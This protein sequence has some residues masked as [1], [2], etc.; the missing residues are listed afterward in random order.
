[1]R[2]SRSTEALLKLAAFLAGL[3]FAVPANAE[4]RPSTPDAIASAVADCWAAIGPKFVDQAVL[5]QRGWR[6]GT[7]S[8]AGG[9]AAQAPKIFGKNGSD[10]LVMLM[11]TADKPMCS[12]AARVE[13]I[14]AVSKAAQAVQKTL[15]AGDPQV[16]T[17]RSGKSVVFLSLPRL[18]TFDSTGTKDKPAVRIVAGYNAE[19]K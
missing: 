16:I 6:A 7:I 1:M 4:L 2:V 5:Q 12:V 15:V 8:N 14:E 9:S 13:S 17:S 11:G 10:A 19:K 3:A 18:A